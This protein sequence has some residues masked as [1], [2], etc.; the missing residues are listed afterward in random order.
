MIDP[1]AEKYYSISPYA[2]VANNPLNA[3]DPDG[4]D[5]F[6]FNSYGDLLERIKNDQP[7][8]FF[9]RD[10]LY[11]STTMSSGDVYISLSITDNAIDMGSNLGHMIRTVY[12]E[13]AGENAETKLAVAEVIRN[14][15]DD[16]NTN[17]AAHGWNA[18]FSKV[19]TYTEVVTQPG[20][21]Q[22]VGDNVPKYSNPSSVITPNGR[23]NEIETASFVQSVGVSIRATKQNTDTA[24]GATYFFDT[25]IPEPSWAKSMQQVTISNG[26]NKMKFYRY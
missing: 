15:A 18:V 3:I 10:F 24:Q 11:T 14:R 4:R 16:N 17:S 19:N 13:A 23:R 12:A 2:Y 1:L 7:D 20:G 6:Y 26:S 21:F 5:S 25:S 8:A 9:Y 22:T